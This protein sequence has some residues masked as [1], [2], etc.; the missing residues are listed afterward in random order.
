MATP[1]KSYPR[2]TASVTDNPFGVSFDI[3]RREIVGTVLMTDFET[4]KSPIDVAFEIAAHYFAEE[5]QSHSA[6]T[7]TFTIPNG[8]HK[9]SLSAEPAE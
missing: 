8:G 5:L 9:F 6:I 7:L 4:G 1:R 2:D 3:E